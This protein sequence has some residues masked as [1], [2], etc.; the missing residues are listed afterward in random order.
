MNLEKLYKSLSITDIYSCSKIS[1]N[2]IEERND[3]LNQAL[4]NDFV[5]Q[6]IRDY[7]LKCKKQTIISISNYDLTL[8]LYYQKKLDINLSQ[9]F[10]T[11]KRII[12]TRKFFDIKG[13]LV[14]HFI[15]APYK[16]YFPRNG[17]ISSKHIN[18]GFTDI[19]KNEIFITRI[20]EYHKVVL[21]EVLH[22]C[23]YI[24]G[25][26]SPT[27]IQKLK[28]V[29]N[30][31][32]ETILLPNEAVVEFWATILVI[33]YISF[34]TKIPFKILYDIELEH[35]ICQST[36]IIEKQGEKE[37]KEKTNS[38]CYIVF[39]TILLAN[40]SEFLKDY[41]FPYDDTYITDFIINHKK[42]KKKNI[43]NSNMQKSLRIMMM[44]D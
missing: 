11:I 19:T 29:F 42:L 24:H 41:K 12:I 14:I 10:L 25:N 7:F 16:R 23:H 5:S 3:S 35:S 15:C 18:G 30:I 9:L 31:S 28:H 1:E 36:I 4:Q 27:N 38:Y 32:K 39:K 8:N 33:K 6:N 37:W 2:N 17:I 34:E 22:H 44:S 21:H 40:V 20:E 43:P 13:S 26:F